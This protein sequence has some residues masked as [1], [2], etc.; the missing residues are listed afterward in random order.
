M[1]SQDLTL[2][3]DDIL[4]AVKET[5]RG[6][7]FVESLESR[8]RTGSTSRILESIARLEDRIE[9]FGQSGEDAVLVK[10]AREAIAAARRDLVRL[11]NKPANLSTE[12]RLFARLAA[13]AKETFTQDSVEGKRVA[14]ALSLVEDLD[15]EFGAA[16]AAEPAKALDSAHLFQ[17]DEAIFEA[18]PTIEPAAAA[19]APEQP[20]E[21]SGRGARVLIHKLSAGVH[22][23]VQERVPETP[24]TQAVG[25]AEPM[26]SRIVVVRRGPG[27][28]EVPLLEEPVNSSASAA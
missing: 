5:A 18:A 21:M 3:F 15:R 22:L 17:P 7:W 1:S 28:A 14:R 19:P 24:A 26:H 9:H 4:A 13:Q 16:P 27:E 6:R 20:K 25:E 8:A 10:K 2:S 23:P 11:E 12:A